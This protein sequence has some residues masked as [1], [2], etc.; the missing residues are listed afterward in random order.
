MLSGV[1]IQ[2]GKVGC[3]A[4]HFHLLKH[5]ALLKVR[6]KREMLWEYSKCSH[7]YAAIRSFVKFWSQKLGIE[8]F[9]VPEKTSSS[10]VL[11]MTRYI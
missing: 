9:I 6:L 4:L 5:N 11:Y 2:E 7:C 10:F 3:R 8:W 1:F